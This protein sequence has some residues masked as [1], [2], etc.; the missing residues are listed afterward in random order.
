MHLAAGLGNRQRRVHAPY[1]LGEREK[2]LGVVLAVLLGM[3]DVKRGH[4]LVIALT[5]EW[6][7]RHEGNLRRQLVALQEAG[8]LL[9]FKRFRA[10]GGQRTG[11]N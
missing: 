3:A 10:V 5:I 9:R 2:I 1:F 6:A 4:E 7:V 11:P 8:H